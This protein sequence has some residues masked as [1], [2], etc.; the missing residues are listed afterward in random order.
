MC[1]YI[2]TELYN[3]R[4]GVFFWCKFKWGR[5]G[6]QQPLQHGTHQRGCR[7]PVLVPVQQ[8]PPHPTPGRQCFRDCQRH[9]RL[10][11]IGR[12]R[13]VG[14]PASTRFSAGGCRCGVGALHRRL[15]G[16]CTGRGGVRNG[17]RAVGRWVYARR[18]MLT[19]L[20]GN[21]H[22]LV[23]DFLFFPKD[24]QEF[25]RIKVCPLYC[26]T[27]TGTRSMH[28]PAPKN[29]LLIKSTFDKIHF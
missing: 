27:C 6:A 3:K 11:S 13:W 20:D 21:M 17:R 8:D 29:P 4:G 5:A 22:R 2:I 14:L 15:F 23:T 12:R 19:V 25:F 18:T 1:V 26:G 10:P 28:H 16:T 9:G 24:A 7:L